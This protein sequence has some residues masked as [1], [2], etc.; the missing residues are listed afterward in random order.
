MNIVALGYIGLEVRDLA[1]WSKFCEGV[2]GL[3]PAASADSGRRYRIDAQAWRI[4]LA[5]GDRDDL[6]YAGFEVADEASLRAIRERFHEAGVVL[7]PGEPEL[8][9]R[10]G[11]TELVYCQDP[12]GL[13]VEVYYGPTLVTDAPFVSP[14]GAGGF[15]A[16][17]QG[18]GHIVLTASRI[19]ETRHFYRDLLGFRLSDIIRMGLGEA[20]ALDLEFYHCN[21]RHHTLALVPVGAP[22]R[23]LHFMLQARVLDDVGFALDR[24]LESGAPLAQTLG[25]H[26]NDQMVSFY[27]KTPSG[28]E[29]EYGWG[30]QEVHDD[31]WRVARHDKPSIWGHKRSLA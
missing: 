18:L 19:D 15:V 14:I 31:T 7:T 23:L 10:R 17:S 13:R 12:D 29:V 9:A 20:G 16:D 3:M 25:R 5:E 28:F 6:S 22:K 24:V 1:A 26:T 27:V 8:L 21:P 11:V 4:D 30:G 2:L